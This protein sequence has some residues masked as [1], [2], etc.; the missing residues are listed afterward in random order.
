MTSK[1]KRSS[2]TPD[3]RGRVAY[4]LR[5]VAGMT[6]IPASTLRTMVRRGDLNPI[7]S[8]GV[9]LISTEELERLLGSRL[10]NSS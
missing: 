5:E 6:G 9:W 3:S 1:P 4:R 7:T 10:R 2:L 8:F